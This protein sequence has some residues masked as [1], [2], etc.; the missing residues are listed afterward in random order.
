MHTSILL[1]CGGIRE[2]A[3][4][5]AIEHEFHIVNFQDFRESDIRYIKQEFSFDSLASLPGQ[6]SLDHF[7]LASH[8]HRLNLLLVA[9]PE[10]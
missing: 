4:I 1:G 5:Q 3:E 8:Q 9:S 10:P 6:T 7:S 2:A